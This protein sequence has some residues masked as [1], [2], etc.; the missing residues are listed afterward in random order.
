[1]DVGLVGRLIQCGHCGHSG[2]VVARSADGDT[3]I[4]TSLDVYTAPG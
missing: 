2:I 3:A 1:M 4:M